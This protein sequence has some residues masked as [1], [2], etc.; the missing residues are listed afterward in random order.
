MTTT[1]TKRKE[2]VDALNPADV[3][4]AGPAGVVT[5]GVVGGTS[6]GSH[7]QHSSVSVS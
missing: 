2:S 4:G 6:K 5:A 7:V 1:T 3:V